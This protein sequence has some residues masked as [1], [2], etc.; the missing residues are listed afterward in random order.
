MDLLKIG[1]YVAEKRKALGLTQRQV[2]ERL[3]MSDKSVSKWERGICLPDVS[4][5]EEYCGILGISL[6]EF[7]AGEDIDRADLAKK[8]EDNLIQ[9]TADGKRRRRRL[10]AIIAVLLAWVI[11]AMALACAYLVCVHQPRNAILPVPQNSPEMRTA[12]LL[13]GVDGAFLYRFRTDSD[14]RRLMVYVSEYRAGKLLDKSSTG[15]YYEPL[16]SPSES[17]LAIVPDFAAFSVKLV[18]A[19]DCSRL[20]SDIPILTGAEGREYFGRSASPL[21]AETDIRLG[22]EQYLLA[23]IYDNNFMR[24]VD[25]T[26]LEQGNIPA[27][28]DYMYVFSVCFEKQAEH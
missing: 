25:I 15:A 12:E 20:S 11:A 23:L 10:K 14:F 13:S 26:E 17:I 24:V 19:D 6:N 18:L 5:Y 7:L 8:S 9:L 1:K 3:G 27:D 16:G 4:V 2:A 28:N 21:R 22:E